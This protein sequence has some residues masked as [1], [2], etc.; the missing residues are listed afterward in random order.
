MGLII[1]LLTGFVFLLPTVMF[2]FVNISAEELKSELL[3][4]YLKI[5]L[6]YIQNKR[7]YGF[8]ALEMLCSVIVFESRTCVINGA[9]SCHH[10][11]KISAFLC[12]SLFFRLTIGEKRYFLNF[13]ALKYVNH[14]FGSILMHFC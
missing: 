1:L 14:I 11:H 7:I 2:I 10:F 13:F 8:E 5:Y 12:M 4:L 6:T 3:T 9:H